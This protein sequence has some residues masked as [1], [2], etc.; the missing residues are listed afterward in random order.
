MIWLRFLAAG[1]LYLNC[2]AVLVEWEGVVS[3]FD[4]KVAGSNTNSIIIF[5]IDLRIN[6]AL[7]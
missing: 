5:E 6:R 3:R 7:G 1:V 2:V 4:T